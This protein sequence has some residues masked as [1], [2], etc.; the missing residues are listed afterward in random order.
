MLYFFDSTSWKSSVFPS[1]CT[2]QCELAS[3]RAGKLGALGPRSWQPHGLRTGGS[4]PIPGLK[5]LSITPFHL[6]FLL[7]GRDLIHREGPPT[8][9]TRGPRRKDWGWGCYFLKFQAVPCFLQVEK[10]RLAHGL[11]CPARRR[12]PAHQV[13]FKRMRCP[14]S[15]RE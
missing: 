12:R 2:C 10:W 7:W 4:P 11:P 8:P 15:G 6:F 3:E 14:P 9:A 1:C 13:A 5:K